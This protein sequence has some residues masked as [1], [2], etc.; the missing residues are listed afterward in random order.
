MRIPQRTEWIFVFLL[1]E[2]IEWGMWEEEKDQEKKMV[3]FSPH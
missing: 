1:T 3:P 2:R